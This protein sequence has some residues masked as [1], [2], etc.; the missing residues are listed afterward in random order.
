MYLKDKDLVALL[1]PAGY[2]ADKNIVQQAQALLSKWGLHSYV[3]NNALKQHGHFAGTD[4][5]RLADLQEALD[6][7]QVKMIW[8]LRGGYGSIRIVDELD[9]TGFEKHPKLLAGFS[10]ISILHNRFQQTGVESLHA[11]MPVQLKNKISREVIRQTKNAIF[12]RDVIYSF[13]KSKFTTDF[14]E[15]EAIVTGGN[16]ANLYS[17]LGTDLDIDTQGKIL[18]IE[19]VGEQL[20]QIDRMIIALKKAG[21]FNGLKALLV[22]Q[23]T[24]IPANEPDFGKSYQEI[25][26][27]HTT[28]YDFPVIF[29]APIGHITDNYPLILGQN[30]QLI[31]KGE[32]IELLQ[33]LTSPKSN[34]S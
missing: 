17:L 9:F 25:I 30:L 22:G 1:S 19:D 29:D 33:N 8:A 23:F 32:K 24:D 34:L 7:P 12:G 10:D 26:L 3:G 14:T 31:K 4:A 6:N 11:F 20:Y 13:P 2:L 15:A 18:F 21:K 28:G 16:L 5:Q 27:E